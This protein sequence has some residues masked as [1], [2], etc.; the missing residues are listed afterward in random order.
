[1]SF[2][3]RKRSNKLPYKKI[4]SSLPGTS[5]A[6]QSSFMSDVKQYQENDKKNGYS[7]NINATFRQIY[8]EQ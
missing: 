5:K 6:A 8:G 4:R 2:S 3:C 1:M 7:T